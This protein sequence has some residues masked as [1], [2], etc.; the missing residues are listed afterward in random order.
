MPKLREM[1]K[2]KKVKVSEIAKLLNVSDVAVYYYEIGK[3][4]ISINHIKKLADFYKC[5][6]EDLID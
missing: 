4:K 5:T 6:I 2:A 1:R 3:R